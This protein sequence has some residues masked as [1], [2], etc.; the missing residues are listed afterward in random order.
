MPL[1]TDLHTHSAFSDGTM[2]PEK[3]IQ[4]A[5]NNNVGAIVIS[6]H[7]TMAGTN[8]AIKHAK[9]NNIKIL[10]GIEITAHLNTLS[11]H[12]L[13]YG[14]NQNSTILNDTLSRIQLA[15]QHRNEKIFTRLNRFGFALSMEQLPQKE[16]RQLGRPHI[17][18]LLVEQKI[19][20][21]EAEA[22][23]R[24]L[25]KD[26]AA[27]VARQKLPI[28]DA[29]E[30]ITK[31]GGLAILAHPGNL[32][33]SENVLQKI[34]FELH[35][36]GI[37]GIEVYHPIHSEKLVQFLQNLCHNHNLLITGGSDFHGR[38]RDK[39]LIGHHGYQRPLPHSLFENLEN[40]LQQNL[41]AYL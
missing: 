4:F 19:V 16:Y 38:G 14:L 28:E 39:A 32:R 9:L 37:S 31:A 27:Y 11:V 26:A 21:S 36:M 30:C 3:L 17:A 10:P 18:K 8:E 12:I 2:T 24:F 34:I 25:R 35:E 29:I 23:N 7:D 33:V 15:R 20:R 13:G 5:A 40:R 1:L 41:P 22:F 6:D